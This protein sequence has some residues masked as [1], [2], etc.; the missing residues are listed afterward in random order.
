M[1]TV[2]KIVSAAVTAARSLVPNVRFAVDERP[3]RQA[4]RVLCV[5][6]RRVAAAGA[7]LF[8]GARVILDFTSNAVP[9]AIPVQQ[10][11]PVLPAIASSP[12]HRQW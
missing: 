6:R 11:W 8:T 3:G 1:K 9:V 4:L 10:F 2:E 5:L 12:V 7:I